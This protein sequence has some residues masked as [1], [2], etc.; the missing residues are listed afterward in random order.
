[1]SPAYF[2]PTDFPVVS[3][4]GVGHHSS[5]GGAGMGQ[6]AAAQLAAVLQPL[7]TPSASSDPLLRGIFANLVKCVNT[8][9]CEYRCVLNLP[10]QEWCPTKL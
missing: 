2:T 5:A 10:S 8:E 4:P 9:M 1:M 6:E 3:Q 7:L